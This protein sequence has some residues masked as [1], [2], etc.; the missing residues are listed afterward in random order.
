MLI[1]KQFTIKWLSVALI[2]CLM[3]S[4]NSCRN[5]DD[6]DVI[7]TS[8]YVGTWERIDSSDEGAV[9]QVLVITAS[10]FK[11]TMKLYIEDEWVDIMVVEGSYSVSGDIFTLILTRLG[12]IADEET[13]VMVYYTPDD[14]EWDM[15][16]DDDFEL[17]DSFKAKFIVSGNKL[18]IIT[19]DNGDG[20]FDPVEESETFTRN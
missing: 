13:L 12:M 15:L 5:D 9:K 1:Q 10:T 18:T 17:E 7:I 20:I 8:P 19:D 14:P 4:V 2:M 16:L 6:N 11:M 3:F